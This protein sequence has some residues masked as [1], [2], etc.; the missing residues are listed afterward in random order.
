MSRRRQPSDTGK[1]VFTERPSAAAAMEKLRAEMAQLSAANDR[2]PLPESA[3]AEVTEAPSRPEQTGDVVYL[4]RRVKRWRAST[5]V[6][7]LLAASLLGLIVVREV[8]PGLL[9][10]PL[11][12]TPVEVVRTVEVVK[13][14]EVPAPAPAEYVAVL[15]KDAASPAFILTFDF[16][17]RMVMARLV[18]AEH[19]SGRS[20][21]L[22]LVSDKLPTPKSLGVIGAEPFT[23]R[24]ALSDFD[25]PT[26]NRATYAVSLEPQGGS[27]TGL[28]TGPVL[29]TG[30]LVQ[31]TPPGL[32]STP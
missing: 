20:Y 17:K 32:T 13:T 2:E 27:P 24:R 1:I 8:R 9:P 6:F 25:M 18:G 31:A 30:K 4:S 28:P 14:V 21:E 29:Y 22:W 11:K 16:E 7:G 15:Q 19:Q 12:P 3:P 10:K 26:I 5:A 23:V